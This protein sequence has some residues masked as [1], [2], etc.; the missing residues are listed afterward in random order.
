[1][2]SK[3]VSLEEHDRRSR[4]RLTLAY[5]VR[6]SRP[7]ES[8]PIETRTEDLTCEGFYCLSSRPFSPHE[9]LECELVIPGDSF[10]CPSDKDLVLSCMAE[11]V[12]IV[13]QAVGE[14]F[15]VACRLGHYTLT[16]RVPERHLELVAQ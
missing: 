14:A 10:D 8:R 13:P 4:A 1:M 11:V 2:L 12:R 7:G 6:I 5:P 9:W 15:G 3:F 16:R